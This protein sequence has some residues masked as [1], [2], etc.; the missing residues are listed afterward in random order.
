MNTNMVAWG[1][2]GRWV[3]IVAE[4]HIVAVKTKVIK[5]SL[6]L[7]GRRENHAGQRR[8]PMSRECKALNFCAFF[9]ANYGH[10]RRAGA[11]LF[12]VVVLTGARRRGGFGD[13]TIASDALCSRA[14][15]AWTTALKW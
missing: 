14:V 6:S 8:M 13:A 15:A 3:R 4:G 2:G 1:D 10:Q 11:Q 12:P 7:V 9:T 5:L